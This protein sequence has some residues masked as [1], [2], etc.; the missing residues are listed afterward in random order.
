MGP[1]LVEFDLLP[2]LE[3]STKSELG[4]YCNVSLLTGL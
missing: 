4:V 1:L 2:A 3:A